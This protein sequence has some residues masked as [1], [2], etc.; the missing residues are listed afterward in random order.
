MEEIKDY[1]EQLLKGEEVLI[2]Y[3]FIDE[4]KHRMIVYNIYNYFKENYPH[5]KLGMERSNTAG[6][7]SEKIYFE[8]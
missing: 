2:K 7:I 3:H 6:L 1:I 5:I 8:N 4:S